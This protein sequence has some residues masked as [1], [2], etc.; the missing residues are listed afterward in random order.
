MYATLLSILIALFC[1]S[2]ETQGVAAG[3]PVAPR[4][5]ACVERIVSADDA[6]DVVASDMGGSLAACMLECNCDVRVPSSGRGTTRL[7]DSGAGNTSRSL[8]CAARVTPCDAAA[9]Y[10][11]GHV[12]RLFEFNLYR[13]SLRADFFLHALCRLRI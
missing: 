11:A 5:A 10:V 2:H 13:A 7:G 8:R 3:Y 12:T 4:V 6:D 9:G 1:G